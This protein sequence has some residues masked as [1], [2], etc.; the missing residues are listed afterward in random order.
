MVA[1]TP[2]AESLVKS[3]SRIHGES[4]RPTSARPGWLQLGAL[5]LVLLLGAALVQ[6]G[7]AAALYPGGSWVDRGQPGYGLWNNFLCDLARDRAIN[8]SPNP[9]AAW[10]RAGQWTL[11][12]AAAVFWLCVPAL[13][14][15]P[16]HARAVR[17]CGL[18]STL[19]LVL[20]PLTSDALHALALLVGG[21]PGLA[22]VALTVRGL[23]QRPALAL[24]GLGTLVLAAT[25]L[26]LYLA[27]RGYPVPMVITA[28]QR[29]VLVAAAIWMVGC[30]LALVS[31]R[32]GPLE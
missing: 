19:G 26:G 2:I 23:R 27:H 21:I 25:D 18:L 30:A 9:G 16:R 8:R 4:S 32:A 6:L 22:A 11:E 3:A 10:G 15:P 5:A 14:V 20:V 17:A 13:F 12:L 29:I 24:L 28:L 1:R 31:R 7:I